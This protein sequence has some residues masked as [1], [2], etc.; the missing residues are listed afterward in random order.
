MST[1][2]SNPARLISSLFK[3]RSRECFPQEVYQPDTMSEDDT[4]SFSGNSVRE[5]LSREQDNISVHNKMMGELEIH[6]LNST[7]SLYFSRFTRGLTGG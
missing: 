4:T 6:L 3:A 7:G 2:A 5:E 1:E